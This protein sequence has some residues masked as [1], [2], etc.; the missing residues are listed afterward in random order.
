M[1]FYYKSFFIISVL[2]FEVLP[3][4][5]GQTAGTV[6]YDDFGQHAVV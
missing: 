4:I 3:G 5:Q 1:K 6:F 2:L